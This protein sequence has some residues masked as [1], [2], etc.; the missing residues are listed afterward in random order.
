MPPFRALRSKER[1]IIQP[2]AECNIACCTEYSF[3][4]VLLL[5]FINEAVRLPSLTSDNFFET[6]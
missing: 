1:V 2:Y 6:N 3:R 4:S 5:T